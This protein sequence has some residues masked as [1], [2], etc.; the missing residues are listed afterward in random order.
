MIINCKS[1]MK[2]YIKPVTDNICLTINNDVLEEIELVRGSLVTSTM[3][4]N[5]GGF[6]EDED[7]DIPANTSLWED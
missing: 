2:K 6:D 7:W 4:S 3:D 1:I 5:E